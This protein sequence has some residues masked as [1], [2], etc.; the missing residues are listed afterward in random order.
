MTV[1]TCR[2]LSTIILS[3]IFFPKPF[4]VT[5]LIAG[6]FALTG[7]ILNIYTKNSQEVH[8]CLGRMFGN[9]KKSHKIV[10]Y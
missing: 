7:I 9:R 2:K 5:Y 4:V 8:N 1:G 6:I 10:H 3:F